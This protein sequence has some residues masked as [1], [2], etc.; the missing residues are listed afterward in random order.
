MSLSKTAL[1]S[2]LVACW[3]AGLL[4]QLDSWERVR[5]YFFFSLVVVVIAR[6]C[7]AFSKRSAARNRKR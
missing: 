6:F 4:A 5:N 3:I 7:G 1:L 2:I